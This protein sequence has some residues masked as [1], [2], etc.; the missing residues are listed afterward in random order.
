MG[1]PRKCE[2]GGTYEFDRY[3]GAN[4]CDTCGDHDGL[5]RCYCGWAADG[6]NGRQQLI[7]AGENIGDEFLEQEYEDRQNGGLDIEG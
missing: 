2:C 6:G 5:A 1:Q 3:C 4:V 7:E